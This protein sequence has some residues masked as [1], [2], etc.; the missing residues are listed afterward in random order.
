MK[1]I[2]YYII[3][4]LIAASLLISAHCLSKQRYYDRVT[5]AAE[6]LLLKTELEWER[7]ANDPFE[8]VIKI[9]QEGVEWQQP[10][11][12]KK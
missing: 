12:P 10:K 4:T 2:H 3:S 8:Q 1:E 7:K 6:I 11:K 9:L 5:P